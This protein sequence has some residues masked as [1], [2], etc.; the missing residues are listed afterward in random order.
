MNK[1]LDSIDFIWEFS[2]EFREE[3]VIKKIVTFVNTIFQSFT[4]DMFVFYACYLFSIF[5]RYTSCIEEEIKRYL[6]CWEIDNWG[7]TIDSPYD[8]LDRVEYDGI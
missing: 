6:I 4:M 8:I 7:M 5:E 1:S 2:K 3:Y